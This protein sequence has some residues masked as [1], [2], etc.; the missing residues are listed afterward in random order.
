MNLAQGLPFPGRRLTA[1]KNEPGYEPGAGS[2]LPRTPPHFDKE[3]AGIWTRR[4]TCPSQDAASLRQRG[5]TGKGGSRRKTGEGSCK[6]TAKPSIL[7]WTVVVNPGE[8]NGTPLQYACLE[9]PMD[10]GAW[11]AAVHGAAEGR[12]WLSNLAAAAVVV[13]NTVYF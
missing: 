7:S 2:A 3:W 10:G 12:T 6:I 11:W 8:G 4:R 1:T 13:N 5:R 9:N